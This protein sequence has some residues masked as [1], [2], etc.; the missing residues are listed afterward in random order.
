M[1]NGHI[2]F[3]EDKPLFWPIKGKCWYRDWHL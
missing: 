2:E 3:A 1:L